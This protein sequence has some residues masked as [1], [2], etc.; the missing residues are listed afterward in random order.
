[1]NYPT[2][3]RL[4]NLSILL[5]FLAFFSNRAAA[6]CTNGACVAIAP[7][8]SV[9][10]ASQSNLL[11]ALLGNLSGTTLSISNTHWNSLA[12]GNIDL[13]RYLS[14]L[15]VQIGVAT[16]NLALTSN[17]TL[18]QLIAALSSV[19]QANGNSAQVSALAALQAQLGS[20]SGYIK[21]SAFL[22]TS[23]PSAAFHTVN[24]NILDLLIGQIQLFNYQN[25]LGTPSIVTLLGSNIGLASIINSIQLSS[26]VVAPPLMVC[27]QSGA[28][29]YSAALRLKLNLNLV[30]L[31]PNSAS[32]NLLAGVAGASVSLTQLSLYADIARAN[33]SISALNALSQVLTLQAIP[34]AVDIYIG[35]IAD[36]LFFNRIRS[37]SSNDFSYAGLGNLTVGAVVTTT[38][39]IQGKSSASASTA[40][41][42][43]LNFSGNFPQ[44]QTAGNSATFINNLFTLLSQ[45][46]QL[47][48]SP[49]LGVLDTIIL[50]TLKTLTG[51][52]LVPILSSTLSNFVHPLLQF[53]GSG[54]GS[55]AAS[56]YGIASACS[57]SGTIYNDLN[58]N[59]QLDN[60]EIGSGLTLYA[61]LV[62]QASASSA[63]QTVSI[64]SSGAYQFDIVNNGSYNI[65]I[66]A[67]NN[68]SDLTAAVPSN[69]VI[70]EGSNFLRS[71]I[72]MLNADISAQNFGL[73]QNTGST[74]QLTK[75]VDKSSAKPGDILVYS[76]AYQNNSGANVSSLHISDSVPASTTVVSAA[77]GTQPSGVTA[78]LLDAPATAASTQLNWTIQ[79]TLLPGAQGSVSFSVKIAD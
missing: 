35:Q 62:N 16:P 37:L 14:A 53:F 58:R 9:I 38:V 77:C 66:N 11:N 49:T 33:G 71:G 51:T 64:N 22:Q 50:P 23:L 40:L 48:L 44:T 3:F 61:K 7:R 52:T 60:G 75:S 2:L 54:L 10:S 74:L 68:P 24:L 59:S 18:S 20:V 19:A 31:V 41:A 76:I 67:N 34:G 42:S 13:L 17:V 56:V 6:T 30:P 12:Q 55:M 27:S 15:Q 69:W 45:N 32:L 29:F 70:T 36:S 21:L 4:L 5:L 72:N 26:Q 1:M 63:A 25:S 65:V 8:L 57:I 43:T 73:Y 78:C 46:L 39:A 79:G 47:Q 28:I